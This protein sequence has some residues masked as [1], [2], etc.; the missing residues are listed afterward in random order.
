M[1]IPS[2]WVNTGSAN[3]ILGPLWNSKVHYYVYAGLQLCQMLRQMQPVHM[4]EPALERSI[5]IFYLCGLCHASGGYS[6]VCH[7]GSI[8]S[9]PGQFFRDLWWTKCLWVLRSHPVSI[10]PPFVLYPF[11]YL[12]RYIILATESFVKL[13]RLICCLYDIKVI[14]FLQ[15]YYEI[16]SMC[17]WMKKYKY[18]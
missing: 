5:S 3:Q 2:W 18:E 17:I 14:F 13:T 10:I 12:H 9:I 1:H 7:H 4:F 15:I 16:F 8:V 11:N 6:P